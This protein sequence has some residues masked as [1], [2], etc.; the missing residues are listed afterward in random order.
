MAASLTKH[1]FDSP[2]WFLHVRV[3]LPKLDLGSID[4]VIS[5]NHKAIVGVRMHAKSIFGIHHKVLPF[6]LPGVVTFPEV[7]L[8][9]TGT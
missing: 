8:H 5:I 9:W 4:K 2:T 6:A 3:A 1:W 7:D